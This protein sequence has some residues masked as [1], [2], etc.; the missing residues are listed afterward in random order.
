MSIFDKEIFQDSR[1]KARHSLATARIF[2]EE[3]HKI[4]KSKMVIYDFTITQCIHQPITVMR[5]FFLLISITLAFNCGI[6]QNQNAS[7]SISSDV[8]ALPNQQINTVNSS[9]SVTD[10][11]KSVARNWMDL[12]LESIRSDYA[13]PTVHARNLHHASV[14]MY[15]VWAAYENTA[16]PYFLGQT[17]DGYTCEFTGIPGGNVIANRKKAISFAMYRFL[18]HRFQNSPAAATMFPLY[19]QYMSDLGYNINTTFAGYS[20]GNAAALG[21]YIAQE[22]INMGLQDGSN[23]QTDYSN[24]YYQPMNAPLPMD[25]PGNP[26][27]T[28]Y[29]R[30]QP[31]SLDVYIDQ[32]GNVIPINVPAFLSPE[33]GN[34]SDFCLLETEKSVNQRNGD[35]YNIYCDPGPPPYL[36][37]DGGGTSEAYQWGFA[38]VS[39]WSS[40]LDA[41]DNTMWDIS[42]ASIGNIQSYPDPTDLS[43]MQAFYDIQNGGDLSVGHTMNPVTGMPYAPQMVKRA[44]YG[45]VLAEFWADG[46]DSE[47]P[48][49]HWFTILHY[50]NDHPDFE[51]RFE[52]MGP[53][54]DDLEWDVKSYF[55]LGGAMHDAAVS[56]WGIKGWYDYIRPVSAIRGMAELGQ[57]SDASLPS[58]H[59]GGLP[60]I[61]GYIELVNQGDALAG[62]GNQNVGKI[63]LYA[64]QG[65]DYITTASP[66]AGVD[67]ILAEEWWPYQ[68]PTFVTPP[69]AGYVSGHSTFSR[70]AAEVMTALTGDAFF[71]G[72]M[73]EFEAPQNNFLVFE[74]GPSQDITL[75][76]AT[77]RDASDQCSLSRI[78]GG[79]HPPADDIPGRLIGMKIGVDAFN[80]SK[81]YFK[82]E[83]ANVIPMNAGW[84]IISTNCH[85][86][87]DDMKNIFA[88]ISNDI[89]QVKNITDVYVPSANYSTFSGWDVTQGYMVKSSKSTTLMLHSTEKVDI[90]TETIPLNSGWNI[91]AYWL[92]GLAEPAD[93]FASFSSSIVQVKNLLGAFVPSI[94]YNGM[95]LM[96]PGQGYQVKMDNTETLMFD[97]NDIVPRPENNSQAP[98]LKSNIPIHFVRNEAPHLN[99]STFI[100]KDINGMFLG[101][102][103]GIFAQDGSLA[104]SFVY[105]GGDKMGGLVYGKE[106]DAEQEGNG[107][108]AGDAY[109]VKY[110]SAT[111]GEEKI[112]E[113]NYETGKQFFEKD[114][115]IIASL[116]NTSSNVGTSITQL[117]TDSPIA[118]SILGMT[119]VPANNQLEIQFALNTQEMTTIQVLNLNGQILE[120]RLLSDIEK[121]N[122]ISVLEVGNYVSGQY[123]VRLLNGKSELS[124]TFVKK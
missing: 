88:D 113:L 123:I 72:G 59:V 37:S 61:P 108:E 56:A 76:W 10:P 102:E 47:T 95:G 1:Q 81:G 87:N 35:N 119:P 6:A 92:D 82:R 36:E 58:Y 46:P 91:I 29:N 23:E 116:K 9:V 3:T 20:T 124:K 86:L 68:R 52:G 106:L 25:Y 13:R 100:I 40:H 43:Q 90:N 38:L 4:S 26:S 71:P 30:W 41:A 101:D 64:W 75:Q 11:S 122:G 24:D 33:W 53:I 14:L 21:N 98:E 67:W 60:L 94:N 118:M 77:Y 89:V 99:N 48:P 31:L 111:N 17:V 117:N 39:A 85:L 62:T 97:A 103:I 114:D 79:I 16:V 32:S 15:D 74:E 65:P 57:S 73:G 42:P 18:R 5:I 22:I 70:A 80:Y 55:I 104:A 110:W 107:L 63:K 96:E 19:D 84:N 54:L 28:D 105:N 51:K 27:L 8:N 93:V 109:I 12:L 34:V 45:R 50:V 7:P 2:N 83:C 49:G 115:L 121:Q 66:A 44:D 69:F 120:E 78:W 112:L